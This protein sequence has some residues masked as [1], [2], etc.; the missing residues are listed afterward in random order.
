MK[1]EQ[2]YFAEFL[3]PVSVCISW[4]RKKRSIHQSVFKCIMKTAKVDN[5]RTHGDFSLHFITS[6]QLLEKKMLHYH[7][8]ILDFEN[9]QFLWID[10]L[11]VTVEY[12]WRQKAPQK[13]LELY[14][15]LSRSPN[16]YFLFFRSQ[17]KSQRRARFRWRDATRSNTIKRTKSFVK[18]TD[19]AIW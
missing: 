11:E 2:N 19:K 7:L 9:L 10:H 8:W 18:P 13:Q 5:F 15:I 6:K 3:F 16:E 1:W 12:F 4:L 17:E 14:F